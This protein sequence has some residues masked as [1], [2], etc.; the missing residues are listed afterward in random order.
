[1]ALLAIP[2][3][4]HVLYKY[5]DTAEQVNGNGWSDVTDKGKMA[6]CMFCGKF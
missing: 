3:F 6:A 1:M 5:F 2:L 4:R